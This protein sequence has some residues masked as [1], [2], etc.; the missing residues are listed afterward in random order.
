MSL[1]LMRKQRRLSP[2]LLFSLFPFPLL[3]SSP[4]VAAPQPP[5]VIRSCLARVE[6]EASPAKYGA[7]PSPIAPSGSMGMGVLQSSSMAQQPLAKSAPPP[8][9]ADMAARGKSAEGSSNI[10]PEN[11]SAKDELDVHQAGKKVDKE[12]RRASE[13]YLSNDDSMSLASAQRLLY[14]VNN[15]LPIYREEIRPHEFLN[16]FHFQTYPVAPGNTFSVKAQ[17]APREKGETLALAVQGKTMT[18][19][20]RRPAV[21]TLVVDKSGSMSAE[22]KMEYLKEGLA[23][24]KSQLKDGDVLNVVEF[25]HETCNAVE[26]FLVGRDAMTGYDRTVSELQPRGSTDLHDGLVEGYKLAERF[27]NP[28][29][30]NR[31]I[32]ITDAIANT[33]ELS[34]DLMASIGKYYDTK[35]IALSGIGVG[36]DFNDELLDTLTDKGKGAYLFIGLR[37]ALPRVF[38]SGFVSLL[39]TVGRDVHFKASFPQNVHL[40]VFYGEEVSTEK[41]KVQPIHYFANTSQLF[42]LD[43]LGQSRP[44][45]SFGLQVEYNDP[46]TNATKTENFNA[47][48]ASLRAAG[49]PAQKAEGKKACAEAQASIADQTR[50]FSDQETQYVSDLTNKYCARF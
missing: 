10:L 40:D 35:Q 3:P 11:K 33:G 43:L 28:E 47:S 15:F 5:A 48:A 50:I 25:D 1:N 30:I 19:E 32:L 27:Y 7:V 22:G 31:V 18:K 16:Y 13:L 21:L 6:Y 44:E 34:P 41:A 36:L 8:P 24:L 38:G 37:E 14:A 9:A 4:A 26:G 45:E 49:T 23:L 20:Q 17:L 39:D 46:I 12:A 2:L 42:L 29:K